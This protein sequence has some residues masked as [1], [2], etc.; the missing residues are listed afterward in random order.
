MLVRS[1][2]KRRLA[3]SA[4]NLPAQVFGG[5]LRGAP[6]HALLW[7]RGAADF[8]RRATAAFKG[9]T[10]ERIFLGLGEGFRFRWQVGKV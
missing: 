5:V 3:V 10:Q 6:K 8:T 1:R 4:L 9:V 2:Y 7:R